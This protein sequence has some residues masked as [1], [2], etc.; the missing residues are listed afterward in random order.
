MMYL[1]PDGR[2]MP[3]GQPVMMYA[4]HAHA[5]PWGAPPPAPGAMPWTGVAPAPA[6]SWGAQ[7]A[8]HQQQAH[9]RA[10][11]PHRAPPWRVGGA[12]PAPPPPPAAPAP[13]PGA[14]RLPPAPPSAPRAAPA[15]ASSSAHPSST[16]SARPS[17]PS[18]PSKTS[19][20]APAPRAS[21]KRDKGVTFPTADEIP[22]VKPVDVASLPEDVRRYRAER[23]KNW[24]TARRVAAAEE[25]DADAEARRAE[26]RERLREILAKQRELGHFDASEEIGD[27]VDAGGKPGKAA[28][29]AAT[30][31]KGK[32]GPG[33]S[34]A[35]GP[36][37]S[38]AGGPGR[39]RGRT[40]AAG[41]G[42]GPTPT[43]WS[44]GAKRPSPF[45]PGATTRDD[46]ATAPKRPRT[47]PD[48]GQGDPLGSDRRASARRCRFWIAGT[49]RKGDAC[50]FSHEGTPRGRESGGDGDG[51][52]DGDG[53]GDGR[54]SNAAGDGSKTRGEENDGEDGEVAPS[55]APSSTARRASRPCRHHARGRCKNGDACAFAHVDRARSSNGKS[56]RG[57]GIGDG[58][59][60]GNSG[61]GIGDGSSRRPAPPTL[62]KRLLARE[63]RADR[64]RL[65][66]TFRFLVNNDFLRDARAARGE[67][68]WMFPW[69][70]DPERGDE[71]ARE[72]IRLA[73]ESA[74]DD[75]EEDDDDDEGDEAGVAA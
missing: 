47:N 20:A 14:A 54:G 66:Q 71:A 61:D 48:A 3:A 12:A 23:A 8:A 10:L 30:R 29:A 24:P 6:A 16:A 51:D 72:R 52:G 65:L 21:S 41:D 74:A 40:A 59:G 18:D 64:S 31:A 26:R 4:P 36:G 73:R 32:G 34:A 39:G 63:M 27:V 42:R 15:P 11:P 49:C 45:E 38:A 62:L 7:T 70:D 46:D 1:M 75:D 55:V 68:L 13:P 35:G 9:Q 33:K 22:E 50:G 44:N 2:M 5:Q 43:S 19:E 58:N 53:N 57:N 67:N 37:K 60:D 17:A 25:D 56:T 69:A 28:R